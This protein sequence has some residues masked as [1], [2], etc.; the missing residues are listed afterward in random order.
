MRFSCKIFLESPQNA[1][2]PPNYRRYLL[3]MIKEALKKSGS[4]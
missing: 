4:D 3:S 2:I 1:I